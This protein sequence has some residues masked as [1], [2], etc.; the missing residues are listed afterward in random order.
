MRAAAGTLA[1]AL[2]TFTL[3]AGTAFAQS[4]AE[5]VPKA[6]LQLLSEAVSLI[7]RN[8]ARA[9][10]DKVLAS[11]CAESLF[12]A[13]GGGERAARTLEAL[14][15]LLL[16]ARAVPG[17]RHEYRRLA[18]FC[19][20]GMVAMLDTHSQYL[21]E[22]ALRRFYA[23]PAETPPPQTANVAWGPDGLL[24]IRLTRFTEQTR[25][26]LQRDLVRLAA[27]RVPLGIVIDLRDNTGGLLY[28]A[29]EVAGLYLDAGKPVG[30]TQGRAGRILQTYQAG[31]PGMRGFGVAPLPESL[32]AALRRAPLA[33]VVNGR[34]ASGAEILAA[35]MQANA[36]GIL[37]G[38]ATKGMGSIQTVYTLGGTS[39]LKLTTSFWLGPK[40]AELDGKP[41][42]PD[43]P[44]GDA[45]ALPAARRWVVEE[46][47]AK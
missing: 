7:K 20:E 25:I 36:R 22:A 45:G 11:G 15:P 21:D 19:I 39:A 10:D 16:R 46:R 38:G 42:E 47:T 3:S 28:A 43:L 9:T 6:D 5:L 14:P 8:F 32:A 26:E 29:I 13:T 30:S 1:L 18:Q 27:G 35:A 4:G 23:Q 12:A 40:D 33:V 34:T 44:A 31:D 24:E 41:L 37:A 17:N 2:A